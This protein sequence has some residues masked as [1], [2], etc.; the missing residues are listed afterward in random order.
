PRGPSGPLTSGPPR[1]GRLVYGSAAR[2]TAVQPRSVDALVLC[3]AR[4]A[5]AVLL[6][7]VDVARAAL[8]PVPVPPE[9]P[10]TEPKRVLGKMLFW[11]EQLSSDDSI[12]CG[13]CHRPAYGGSDPRV[14]RNPR[15]DKGTIDS[16]LGS[17]GSV[18]P[19]ATR[20]PASEP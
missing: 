13:T 5:L 1:A 8:P 14:G 16:V 15:V 3:A 10:I 11:D 7:A 20:D 2:M 4:A 18:S 12:A 6:V 9:N 19:E 17:A